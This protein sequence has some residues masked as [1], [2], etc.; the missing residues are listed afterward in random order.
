MNTKYLM[1]QH[2][3]A[4]KLVAKEKQQNKELH[5]REERDAIVQK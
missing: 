1:L 4:V 3:C 5:E 2:P